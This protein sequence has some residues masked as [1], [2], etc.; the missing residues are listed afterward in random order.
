MREHDC[1][2]S[3]NYRPPTPF[4]STYGQLSAMSI[5]LVV[6]VHVNESGQCSQCNRAIMLITDGAPETH[7]E[8]FKTYNW[9]GEKCYY[10]HISTLADVHEH[11]QDYIH[12]LSRPMVIERIE[13][14]IWTNVYVDK[15]IYLETFSRPIGLWHEN[16]AT[17]SE[18][19]TADSIVQSNH[20][21]ECSQEC[22]E[23]LLI[24]KS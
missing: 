10:S 8:I 24:G 20:Q 4:V 5:R 23:S 9:P 7:E 17:W 16:L 21:F 13:H 18:L 19:F 1:R 3:T 11:V 2:L 12:V 6:G 15:A 14:T 22:S